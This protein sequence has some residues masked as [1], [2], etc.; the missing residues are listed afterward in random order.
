ML[1]PPFEFI[2][3]YANGYIQDEHVLIMGCNSAYENTGFQNSGF[4][5]SGLQNSGIRKFPI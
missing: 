4:Q 3:T 5:I 2:I 1:I